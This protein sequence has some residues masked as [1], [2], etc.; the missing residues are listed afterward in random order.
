MNDQVLFLRSCKGFRFCNIF[1]IDLRCQAMSGDSHLNYS[2]TFNGTDCCSIPSAALS[3]LPGLMCQWN[4]CHEHQREG[5]GYWF[6]SQLCR[7]IT[8]DQLS[9]YKQGFPGGSDGKAPA[10]QCRR[11]GSDPAVRVG[12]IP[13]RRQWHPTPVLLPGKS[14]GRRTLVGDSPWGRKESNTTEK[15]HFHFLSLFK[16]QIT[17]P[18]TN[19]VK[20]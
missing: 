7:K 17:S 5:C 18:T 1:I 14:H 9:S 11:R 8:Y 20:S 6:K 3:K 16:I 19:I 15:L 12:K 13:W 2:S 10:C 4:Q